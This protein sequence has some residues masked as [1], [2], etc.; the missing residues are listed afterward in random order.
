MSI[1]GRLYLR[2]V[3]QW[4]IQD[5]SFNENKGNKNAG[6]EWSQIMSRRTWL[7]IS[8]QKYNWVCCAP[9]LFESSEIGSTMFPIKKKLRSPQSLQ[10][11]YTS[12]P[13]M[14]QELTWQFSFPL[15]QIQTF[16]RGTAKTQMPSGIQQQ[17][18]ELSVPGIR[19][20][21]ETDLD[22]MCS[23][24]NTII[25]ISLI[26]AFKIIQ[27]GTEFIFA[28]S[29]SQPSIQH[30]PIKFQ[31]QHDFGFLWL[32]PAIIL[33]DLFSPNGPGILEVKD[34]PLV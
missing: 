6:F 24:K 3:N 21:L 10:I 1:W 26:C 4:Q 5:Q 15:G 14:T 23:S 28:V 7:L 8:T 13:S 9:E 17:K 31:A 19:Y 32:R 33:F 27:L 25:C 20:Y 29:S 12:E 30:Q 22:R 11:L 34:Y 2:S 16:W 18:N